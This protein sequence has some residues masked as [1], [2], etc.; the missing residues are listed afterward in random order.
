M[1]NK[2]ESVRIKNEKED[3]LCCGGGGGGIW[4]EENVVNR[5]SLIKLGE[6]KAQKIDKIIT[7]CPYCI[8][9]YSDAVS[10][11]GLD[12]KVMDLLELIEV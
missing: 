11:S 9:M 1:N 6:L 10:V 3:S 7:S 4:K 2:Y 5:P 8:S 12:I